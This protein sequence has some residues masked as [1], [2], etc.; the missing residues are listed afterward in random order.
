MLTITWSGK[1][2]GK[3]QRL[4]KGKY[5]N[6]YLTDGYRQFKSDLGWQMVLARCADGHNK[7]PITDAVNVFMEVWVH[8]LRDI[9]SLETVILDCLQASGIIKNDNL[10]IHDP[11]TKHIKRRGEPDRIEVGIERVYSMATV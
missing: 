8:P 9:D 7:Y 11:T 5:G 4:A 6:L 3:N 2:Y 1:A 10:V